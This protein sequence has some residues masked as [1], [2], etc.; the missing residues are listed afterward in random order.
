MLYICER[1]LKKAENVV[2]YSNNRIIWGQKIM[3]IPF[4]HFRKN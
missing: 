1:I 4:A 3:N 2:P